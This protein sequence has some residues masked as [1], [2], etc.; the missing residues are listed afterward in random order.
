LHALSALLFWRLLRRLQVPGAWLASALFALHPV[1]VES[2]AW[3]TERKNV[4]SLALCLAALL[5]YL[6]YEQGKAGNARPPAEALTPAAHSR[7]VTRHVSLY[8]GLALILFLGA[9]LA[10]TMVFPLPAAI[11]L[12]TWWRRGQIRWRED[13]LPTLPFFILSFGMCAVTAW[14]EKTS[15]GAQGPDFALTFSQRFLIAGRAFRFYLGKLFWPA[16]LCFVYPRWQPNAGEWWQWLYP[17][18]A[19][20]LLSTLWLVRGRI[21]RAPV[22]AA[23]LFVGTLFPVLGFVDAYYMRYSFVCDHWVY[24]P[25]L[26]P[27]ALAAG[28]VSLVLRRCGK[29]ERFLKPAV[30]GMVLLALGVLTWNQAEMYKDLQTL[31][32]ATIARNPSCWLAY[33]SLGNALGRKGNL[34][35]AIRLFQEAIQLKPDLAEAYTS[36]G[37]I[38]GMKGQIDEA[39]GQFQEAIRLKPDYAQAHYNLGNALERKGQ[40]DEAIKQFQEAIRLKPDFALHYRLGIALERKG[41]IDEAIRQ[42]E[43]AIRLKPDYAL[44]HY[45]LGILKQGGARP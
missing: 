27:L 16:N 26:G 25:S 8:Y 22:T 45:R 17:V 20:G 15:V 11:L 10:K 42:F 32:R 19:L 18:T 7:R 6:R 28:G 34:D 37:A 5:A 9:L 38:L 4:L 30:S 1:M 21:G 36:I 29:A 39:I 43:E 33:S 31:W 2:A 41:Q 12:L 14:L 13:V 35:G 44:A 24:L 40:T 3:I 23:L